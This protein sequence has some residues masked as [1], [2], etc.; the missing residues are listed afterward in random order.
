MEAE[1]DDDRA[2]GLAAKPA[3]RAGDPFA[4]LRRANNDFAP[5]RSGRGGR[6]LF[7]DGNANGQAEIGERVRDVRVGPDG[8]VYVVT[9]EEDGKLL[10]IE[11]PKAP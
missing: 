9:D 11:P 6:G 1:A 10:R 7:R 2:G 3:G 4:L 5:G 8:N